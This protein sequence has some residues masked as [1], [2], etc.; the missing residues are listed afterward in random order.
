LLIGR[1]IADGELAFFTTGCPAGTRINALVQVAGYR[2]PIK[3]NFETTKSELGLD[4]NET[5]SCHGRHRHVSLV[6]LALAMM[7][8]IRHHANKVTLSKECARHPAL[9]HWSIQ[10]VGS[11]AVRLAQRH[12]THTHIIARSL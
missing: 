4:Y 6:M 7:A 10:E 11:I 9:I 8:V 1:H 2:W 5:R 12:I 3:N